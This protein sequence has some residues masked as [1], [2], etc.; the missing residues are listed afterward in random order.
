VLKD[1]VLYFQ[2]SHQQG[3][4]LEVLE[5]VQELLEVREVEEVEILEE[6]VIVHQ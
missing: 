3:A 6:Q 5:D 1:L 2:Q 4:V